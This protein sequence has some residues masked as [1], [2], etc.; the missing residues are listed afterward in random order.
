MERD[1]HDGTLCA[2]AGFVVA[3]DGDGK[4]G[5]GGESGDGGQVIREEAE[6]AAAGPR[7]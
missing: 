6:E 7:Q 5:A 2:V 4:Y 3:D 1:I